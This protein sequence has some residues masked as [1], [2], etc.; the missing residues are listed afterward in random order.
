MCH[1]NTGGMVASEPG[2][3]LLLNHRP[4]ARR[5]GLEV[6]QEYISTTDAAHGLLVNPGVLGCVC[7]FVFYVL[8]SVSLDPMSLYN[9]INGITDIPIR[10]SYHYEA[11]YNSVVDPNNPSIGLGLGFAN[12]EPGVSCPVDI[13]C[14]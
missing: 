4:W 12:F 14:L 9:C 2:S 3:K 6:M 1:T 7:V 5:H 13:F 10:L 11:H 8:C